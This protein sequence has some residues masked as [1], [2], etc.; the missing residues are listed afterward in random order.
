MKVSAISPLA[1]LLSCRWG[2]AIAEASSID[3]TG[4]AKEDNIHEEVEPAESFSLRGKAYGSFVE[5]DGI[6]ERNLGICNGAVGWLIGPDQNLHWEFCNDGNKDGSAPVDV[7]VEVNL[8]TED[9]KTHFDAILSDWNQADSIQVV[10][11][12]NPQYDSTDATT[13]TPAPN[14]IKVC[15]KNYGATGWVGIASVSILE[16]HIMSGSVRLN[17][18]YFQLPQFNTAAWRASVMCQEMGHIFGLDHWDEDFTTNCD[19]CMDY[20]NQP[21]RLSNKK[22]RDLLDEIYKGHC[23]ERRLHEN[24][25]DDHHNL[26]G[27]PGND[28]DDWGHLVESNS[29]S[30]TYETEPDEHG[31][32]WITK[33]LWVE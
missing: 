13:C 28:D 4:S 22:D 19:S 30:S 17:D 10:A 14:S 3:P 24:A 9:W 31:H 33:V 21:V 1:I 11:V 23:G 29:H 27:P 6:M 26:P 25:E 8:E 18:H 16:V 20:S 12:H 5:V 2:A 7:T 32:Q 15:N